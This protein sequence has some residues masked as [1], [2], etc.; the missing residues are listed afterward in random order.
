MSIFKRLSGLG[1][2]A[3]M[4][5]IAFLLSGIIKLSVRGT[6]DADIIVGAVFLAFGIIISIAGRKSSN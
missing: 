3:I 1:T 6:L 2:T 4:V 5:G